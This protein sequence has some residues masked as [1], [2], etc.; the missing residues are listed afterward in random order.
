MGA[1]LAENREG[2]Q[3]GGKI[4]NSGTSGAEV[5]LIRLI[6]RFFSAKSI[7]DTHKEQA[8]R[9]KVKVKEFEFRNFLCYGLV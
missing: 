9:I 4:G 7:A 1:S 8:P 6:S 5:R 2:S 3:S